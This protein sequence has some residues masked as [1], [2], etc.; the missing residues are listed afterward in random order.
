MVEGLEK[1]GLVL[2]ERPE[3]GCGGRTLPRCRIKEGSCRAMV[4]SG[5]RVRK[6]WQ[7]VNPAAATS[8]RSG[9]TRVRI[10]GEGGGLGVGQ[11]RETHIEIHPL[12]THRYHSFTHSVLITHSSALVGQHGE[13]T[14]LAAK[15]GGR[16]TGRVN[17]GPMK[18]AFDL[19]V[20]DIRVYERRF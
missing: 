1:R 14:F 11:D 3:V 6:A 18:L 10:W 17:K 16:L 13:R 7:N 15:H 19:R 12:P 9:A 4:Y 5:G 8:S 2:V 20:Y